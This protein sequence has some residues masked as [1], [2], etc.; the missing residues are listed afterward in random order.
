MIKIVPDKME[1]ENGA[2]PYYCICNEWKIPIFWMEIQ[3]FGLRKERIFSMQ[4]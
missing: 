2:C 4:I 3:F 1:L